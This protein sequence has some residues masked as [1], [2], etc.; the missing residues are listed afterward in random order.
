MD[1][2]VRKAL[3]KQKELIEEVQR[4]EDFI[5]TYE[6]LSGLLIPR[7]EMIAVVKDG[8]KTVNAIKKRIDGRHVKRRNNVKK[9]ISIS[10][11]LINE[12]KRALTR[13]ELADAMEREGVSVFAND[14]PKYLGT[15]L[16]RNPDRFVQIEGSGYIT[17]EL[18]LA[19]K[20]SIALGG[21][22]EP[23][24]ASRY[25]KIASAQK[26]QCKPKGS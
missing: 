12:S 17:K 5:R 6:E 26:S 16:W 21:Q 7:D 9:L 2:T 18:E 13:G 3:K 1:E 8:D 14:V 11:R 23:I 15:L 19:N 25:L 20:N 4:L 10:E 24:S 22:R